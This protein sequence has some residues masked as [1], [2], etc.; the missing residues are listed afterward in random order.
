M[1]NSKFYHI[2]S[3][4]LMPLFMPLL[5]V[6]FLFQLFWVLVTLVLPKLRR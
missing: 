6:L 2:V 3:V 5:G 1:V 4:V